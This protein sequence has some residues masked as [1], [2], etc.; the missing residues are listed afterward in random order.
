MVGTIGPFEP[1]GQTNFDDT[2]IALRGISPKLNSLCLRCT[3]GG[4]VV[5]FAGPDDARRTGEFS[6]RR[7]NSQKK[8]STSLA[9]VPI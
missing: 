7:G 9:E 6:D 2:R 1:C 8:G 5:G 3:I 4:S